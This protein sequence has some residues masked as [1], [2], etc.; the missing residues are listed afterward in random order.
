MAYISQRGAYWRAEVRRR[1]YKPV[2]RSFDTKQ[3][4]QQWARRVESEMDSGAYVDRT[5]AER[6]TLR[7]ALERYRREIVPEKRHPYQE[8]RR[9]QRWI[10]NDLSHRTLA[11][12]RGAD[13]AKYRDERRAAGR[14]ENTIRLELQVVSHLFEIARK[15]WGMEALTNPLKNIRKPSGSEARDRR[16]RPGE[17]EMLHARLSASGNL[18]AALAFELAIETSLRQGAL[19]SVQW[20]WL[21]LARRLLHFPPTAR[22][23]ENK[24]VPPILP[25]SS[26]A[27]AVFRHLAAIAEGPEARMTRS[28]F[29][30]ADVIPQRLT[31]RVFGTS[32]N[33]VICVW[34]RTIK[35]AS[36]DAPEVSTLRWHDLRHEAAS[37]LFEKG[38]HP[39]EVASVTGHKSM[40][41]L[42]RYTHLRPESLLLKLG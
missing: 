14:A 33:A 1:G 23:T 20:E 21:D 2:Y 13:F 39:M 26:R 42:K 40:Q 8:N 15:E 17:F 10:D 32:V 41:M 27:V 37:R 29:G 12:L 24:G 31:G 25:L 16:L 6:T 30:P 11:N 19:F 3:Q 9:I 38:L 5:E 22:G 28:R 35:R 7:Q 18:W 34:K 36:L 4:A